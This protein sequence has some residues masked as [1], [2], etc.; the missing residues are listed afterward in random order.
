[1]VERNLKGRVG[2]ELRSCKDGVVSVEE[3]THCRFHY[4][5]HPN[6]PA[7]EFL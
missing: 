4:T 2:N 1:M 5:E 3:I 6:H 7:I